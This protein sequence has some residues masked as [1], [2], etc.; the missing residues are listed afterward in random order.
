MSEQKEQE[1][2]L[3]FFPKLLL[4][5]EKRHKKILKAVKKRHKKILAWAQKKGYSI[6]QI[7]AKSTKVLVTG[8]FGASLFLTA[9]AP[10]TSMSVPQIEQHTQLGK[11]LSFEEKEAMHLQ[12]LSYLGKSPGK[13]KISEN[14]VADLISGITGMPA[15]ASFE[16]QKLPKVIGRI[17]GEQHLRRFPQEPLSYHLAQKSDW[18]KYYWAGMAPALGAWGY[19]SDNK[20]SLTSDL[21]EKEK[22]YLAVQTFAIPDWD[23]NWLTLKDWWKFRKMLVYNPANGKSVVAVVADSGPATYTGK[24]FGGSPEVMEALGLAGGPRA[25]EVIILFLNDPQ[26]QIPLGVQEGGGYEVSHA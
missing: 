21:V 15:V 12:L 16:G 19:F 17:G 3:D 10:I 6:N 4:A 24:I 20:N 22:Y 8:V 1:R 13:K 7:K 25:G 18:D 14:L 23:K 9:A 5:L 11:A 26:D 2:K